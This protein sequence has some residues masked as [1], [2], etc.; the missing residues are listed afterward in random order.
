[1]VRKNNEEGRKMRQDGK[2]EDRENRKGERN[3]N[4]EKK[5]IKEMRNE[6]RDSKV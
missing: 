3:E 6:E 2:W 1:V 4:K 5:V